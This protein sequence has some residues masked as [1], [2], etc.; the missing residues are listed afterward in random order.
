MIV[1]C[2]S[3]GSELLYQIQADEA[4]LVAVVA[5]ASVQGV[6]IRT[7]AALVQTLGITGIGR[8]EVSRRAAAPDA[9]VEPFRARPLEAE[10]PYAWPA[11]RY[12]KVRGRPDAVD[13]GGGGGRRARGAGRGGAVAG[14]GPSWP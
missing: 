8:R 3:T 11:A 7:V 4:M 2:G 1:R 14:G 5:A 6:S 13:G 12:T 10:S 9:Q